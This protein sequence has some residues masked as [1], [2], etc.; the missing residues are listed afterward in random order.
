M[1]PHGDSDDGYHWHRQLAKRAGVS[2]DTGPLLR[3]ERSARASGQAAH[4]GYRRYG[5][6]QV[7]RTALHPPRPGTGILRC[8]D[9]SE[10]LRPLR[11][12]DVAAS[13]APPSASLTE[14]N[15]AHRG[16]SA[17]TGRVV[18]AD[19]GSARP[20]PRRRLPHSQGAGCGGH[21]W[22]PGTSNDRTRYGMSVRIIPTWHHGARLRHARSR[23]LRAEHARVPSAAPP[24]ADAIYT[25]PMHPQIRQSRTR[26]LSD[27][28]HGARAASPYRQ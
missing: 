20:R 26:I 23:L 18:R 10:L 15:K 6:T 19:R 12:A 17:G 16:A 22:T 2:I 3:E 14:V 7:S 25:C 5:D 9:I 13:S 11:S 8:E 4:S 27:L 21:E 28:R 1:P 24:A